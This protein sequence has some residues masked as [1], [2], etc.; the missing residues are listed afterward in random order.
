MEFSRQEYWRGCHF[1]FQ[2]IFPTQGSNPALPHCRQTLYPL[3][4]QGSLVYVSTLTIWGC[5]NSAAGVQSIW[6][7]M[8]ALVQDYYWFTLFLRCSHFGYKPK[9]RQTH[10][11]IMWQFWILF[12][13]LLTLPCDQKCYS[14]SQSSTAAIYINTHLQ[15]KI[16]PK[17]KF[18]SPKLSCPRF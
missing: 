11:K 7:W 10:Q 13:F 1:L 6:N 5:R 18:T 16:V 9:L 4:H 17:P 3:S 2:G 15:Q 12:P 8:V 14:M